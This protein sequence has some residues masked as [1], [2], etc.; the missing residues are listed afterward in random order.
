M[1]QLH[2]ECGP[3]SHSWCMGVVMAMVGWVRVWMEVVDGMHV[4]QSQGVGRMSAN[5][6]TLREC[7]VK[8]FMAPGHTVFQVRISW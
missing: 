4:G 6:G 3:V 2:M 8:T 7:E 1:Q 5:A